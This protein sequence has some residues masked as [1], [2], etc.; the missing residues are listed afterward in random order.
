MPAW[1]RVTRLC[2]SGCACQWW[3]SQVRH[4]TSPH[5]FNCVSFTTPS[6]ICQI[7]VV[8]PPPR[9]LLCIN[10]FWKLKFQQW[11]FPVYCD[12]AIRQSNA[13]DAGS[14]ANVSLPCR[15]PHCCPANSDVPGGWGLGGT[16]S[17]AGQ[18]RRVP[19]GLVPPHSAGSQLWAGPRPM[20]GRC[21]HCMASTEEMTMPKKWVC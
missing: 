5:P 8:S 19:S 12:L 4:T 14:A 2:C 21:G 13:A 18:Q 20:A 15:G 11:L 1:K 10:F 7:G 3:P 17:A 6:G 16:S 9:Y